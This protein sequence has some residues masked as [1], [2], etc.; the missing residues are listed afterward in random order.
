MASLA[1]RVT[2]I[3][4]ATGTNIKIA[5]KLIKNLVTLPRVTT[6]KF[7]YNEYKE[8]SLSKLFYWEDFALL[9]S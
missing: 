2:I 3:I 8:R 9:D 5:K 6:D 1:S 4:V 7:S